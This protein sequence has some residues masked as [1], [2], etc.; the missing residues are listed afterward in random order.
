MYRLGDGGL[1][2]VHISHHERCVEILQVLVEF[3][4]T[5]VI[6]RGAEITILIIQ[7]WKENESMFDKEIIQTRC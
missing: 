6:Y 7:Y 5:Q 1:H 2:Q 3:S 4:V